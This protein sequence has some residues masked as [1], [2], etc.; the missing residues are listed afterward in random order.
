MIADVDSL[1]D[2]RIRELSDRYGFHLVRWARSRTPVWAHS[3]FSPEEVVQET[4]AAVADGL[5]MGVAAGGEGVLC[6]IR[7]T[8]H[9]RLLA[10]V[11]AAR[12]A[13]T[14]GTGSPIDGVRLPMGNDAVAADLVERYEQSLLRLPPVERD[15]VICRAE[16]GLPWSDITEILDRPGVAS[17]RRAVCRALVHLAREMADA[18]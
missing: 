3:A 2:R 9:D 17:A 12:S 5:P 18:R 16:L 10:R 1:R 7:Q 15:A 8:M 6:A 13:A 14:D 11:R 4:L